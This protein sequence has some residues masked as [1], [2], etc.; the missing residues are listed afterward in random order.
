[1]HAPSFSYQHSTLPYQKPQLVD[2]R[3]REWYRQE[4]IDDLAGVDGYL[5]AL[6]RSVRRVDN[7][8]G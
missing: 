6:H 1:M 3:L 5:G 7:H 2:W 4:G 8:L